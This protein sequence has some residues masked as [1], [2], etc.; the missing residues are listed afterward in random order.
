[1]TRFEAHCGLSE[2]PGCLNSLCHI[3]TERCFNT[4][5]VRELVL[6]HENSFHLHSLP[7]FSPSGLITA[8]G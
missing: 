3:W 6:I 1:M 8:G 5:W 4:S 2:A 7:V